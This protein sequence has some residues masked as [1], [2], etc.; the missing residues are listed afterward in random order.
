MV[1]HQESEGSGLH[2][3][4]RTLV[5]LGRNPLVG[6]HHRYRQQ[7]EDLICGEIPEITMVGLLRALTIGDSTADRI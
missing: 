6:I 3:R 1:V 7:I 2:K 4:S 5:S